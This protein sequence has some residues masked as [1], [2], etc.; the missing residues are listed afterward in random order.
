MRNSKY[1]S[2]GT[3]TQAIHWVTAM[4]VVLAFVLGPDGSEQHIYSVSEELGRRVHESLGLSV[5]GLTTFRLL[6]RCITPRP[7]LPELSEGVKMASTIVQSMLYVLLLAL[8]I[9]AVAGA[10]LGGHPVTLLG[11]IDIASPLDQLGDLGNALS[12]LHGLLGDAVMWVAGLHAT[13]ALYH[14]F[15]LKD[16]VLISMLPRWLKI[17][18]KL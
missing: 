5:F 4:V 2:Y 12:E 16:E 3:V 8:P 1:A 10:W 6:W 15:F 9:T 14:H 11:R 7:H 13:A 18:R 17:L